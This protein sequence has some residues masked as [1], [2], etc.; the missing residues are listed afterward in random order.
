MR[1]AL[2]ALACLALGLGAVAVAQS[3]SRPSLSSLEAHLVGRWFTGHGNVDTIVELHPDHTVTVSQQ[4]RL[5]LS[6]NDVRT[7]GPTVTNGS[8]HVV[9]GH[10]LLQTSSPNLGLS[11]WRKVQ[12]LV[13]AHR[14]PARGALRRDWRL[15]SFDPGRF[16]F[17][18]AGSGRLGYAVRTFAVA[19]LADATAPS[20]GP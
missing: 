7:V 1:S 17:L 11:P 2:V 19:D 14:W 10:L 6:G 5:A 4:I 18:D 12:V 15:E 20:P 8:W 13:R 3:F 9:D 16:S